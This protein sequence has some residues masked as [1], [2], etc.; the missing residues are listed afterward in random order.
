M[1]RTFIK[2]KAELL[3]RNK[4]YD[5]V[6]FT[7]E[8][9][10]NLPEPIK[11][12]LKVCGYMNTPV[13]VNA[14]VNWK[15]C[16]FKM[17]PKKDWGKIQTLQFNSVKPIARVAYMKFS[18][19]P[20]SARDIYQDGY[21]EMKVT[22]LNLFQ[23]AFENSKETAQSALITSFA[24]FLIIP[25]YFVS[26][27]VKWETINDSTLRA[28]LTDYGM[29]VTG[30]FY[31]NEEGLLYKFETE[32]RFYSFGKNNYK[33]IKYSGIVDSFKKQGG[34]IIA[35]NVNVTWHLPEGD[36]EYFKGIIE[37]IKFNIKE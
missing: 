14:N 34:I 6:L 36:F 24:E 29:V 13:P 25:G 11:K 26:E 10:R 32:D 5:S 22:L 19:M 23:I 33:K 18:S 1:K 35:E 31:L 15:E 2:E 4:A 16:Y 3:N 21:G 8:L 27:N 30:L 28:T 17:S 37:E 9:I 20:I 12:H 7:N